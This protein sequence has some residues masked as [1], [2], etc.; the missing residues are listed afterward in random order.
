MRTAADACSWVEG[1]HALRV[2]IDKERINVRGHPSPEVLGRV[3]A[4]KAPNPEGV[5]ACSVR[6]L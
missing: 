3:K 4:N 6:R 1:L 2:E 5:D